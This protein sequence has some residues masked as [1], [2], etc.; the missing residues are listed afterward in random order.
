MWYSRRDVDGFRDR[1]KSMYRAGFAIS[2]DGISWT[3][4]DDLAALEP[5]QD[6]WDS[7]AIAYPYAIKIVDR[8]LLFYNG[9]GFGRTGFGYAEGEL[10]E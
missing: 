2:E 10:K 1:R 7:E 3:R 8:L 4:R 6:G 9:N 5:S